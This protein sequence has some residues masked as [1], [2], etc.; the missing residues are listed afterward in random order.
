MTS[1]TMHPVDKAIIDDFGDYLAVEKRVSQATMSIY[2]RE[3]AWYLRFLRERG[4][5]IEEATVEDL[6]AFLVKRSAEKGLS[7]RTQ[8]RNMSALRS[9]HRYVCDSKMR[10]DNPVDLLEKPRVPFTLPHSVSLDEVDEL[11]SVID[12]NDQSLLGLR[13][14][15]LF[16][17][18][19]SCGLR[20]S[21][22]CSLTLSDYDEGQGLLRVIGKGNKERIVPVGEVAAALLREYITTVRPHLLGAQ[23]HQQTLFLGRRGKPLT[24]ALVWKRF[25]SYCNLAHIDAKVHTLRHS[26]ATHLLRGGADLRVVQELL[27]HSDIRTTQIYTHTDTDDLKQAYRSFHPDGK[28]ETG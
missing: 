3:A 21:E 24:R 5:G 12:A 7:A 9:F 26:F 6:V 23:H 15:A 11:F 1:E 14:H 22:A 27:G 17:L 16:E 13:D 10:E 25:K 18:I 20:V 8:A 19:Y 4:T 2:S 28:D